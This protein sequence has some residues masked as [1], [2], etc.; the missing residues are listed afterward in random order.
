MSLLTENSAVESPVSKPRYVE[1]KLIYRNN[2]FVVSDGE[3]FA[4]Y[5]IKLSVEIVDA[6]I[7]RIEKSPPL[8]LE[9]WVLTNNKVYLVPYEDL[10]RKVV[11]KSREIKQEVHHATPES[12]LVNSLNSPRDDSLS[13]LIKSR[14]I[15]ASEMEISKA[16]DAAWQDQIGALYGPVSEEEEWEIEDAP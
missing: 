3:A 14:T 12:P 1:T 2:Y 16:A 8:L 7:L 11:R 4:Y 6:P 5:P 15:D 10:V 13:D 9:G